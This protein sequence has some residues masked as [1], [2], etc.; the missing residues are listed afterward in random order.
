MRGT[1]APPTTEPLSAHCRSIAGSA[2][3]ASASAQAPTPSSWPANRAFSFF[4][5]TSTMRLLSSSTRP[6]SRNV[7]SPSQWRAI[8]ASFSPT[9]DLVRD[10]AALFPEPQPQGFCYGRLAVMSMHLLPHEIQENRLFTCQSFAAGCITSTK[11]SYIA[12]IS[13]DQ[14]CNLTLVVRIECRHL[15]LCPVISA[16]FDIDCSCVLCSIVLWT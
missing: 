1:D 4:R 3:R 16:N 13:R 5:A 14:E 12:R 9:R 10:A 15:P 11:I 7:C 8:H 2:L 6:S